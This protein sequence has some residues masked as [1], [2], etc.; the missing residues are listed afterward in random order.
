MVESLIIQQTLWSL[1]PLM[2]K[3]GTLFPSTLKVG[4]K[5][6]ALVFLFDPLFHS[7]W[8]FVNLVGPTKTSRLWRYEKMAIRQFTK[9][10]TK[11]ALSVFPSHGV[12]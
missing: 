10:S 11:M 3:K 4:E 5:K 2:Q 9:K 7:Y 6:V 1:E 12:P 8:H